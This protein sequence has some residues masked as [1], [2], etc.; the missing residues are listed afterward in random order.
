M[1]SISRKKFIFPIVVGVL[2]LLGAILLVGVPLY[3]KKLARD[4][5][6]ELEK[7]KPVLDINLEGL[8]VSFFSRGVRLTRLSAAI[9][10]GQ[11][12]RT[13]LWLDELS[14]AGANL[15]LLSNPATVKGTWAKNLTL[16]GLRL[17]SGLG[18]ATASE[19]SLDE[20]SGDLGR[21]IEALEQSQKP[22]LPRERQKT[23]LF[24]AAGGISMDGI[25]A[26]NLTAGEAGG[27]GLSLSLE[28]LDQKDF[29][30]TM[31]G[32][33]LAKNLELKARKETIWK[34]QTLSFTKL[35]AP[36][37]F[38][39][40]EGSLP[41]FLK[42]F[43]ASLN[44]KLQEQAVKAPV[45]LS[46]LTIAGARFQNGEGKFTSFDELLLDLNLDAALGFDFT[47][48]NL[49]SP[50]LPQS[51]AADP[52]KPMRFDAKG[53]GSLPMAEQPGKNTTL[54]VDASLSGL[55]ALH[56]VLNLSGAGWQSL[57]G[58]QQANVGEKLR[59]I[60]GEA[61]LD[62]E[63]RL[64]VFLADNG[65]LPSKEILKREL[66]KLRESAKKPEQE[67]LISQILDFLNNGGAFA[68]AV[69]PQK[70]ASLND[71]SVAFVLDPSLL[72]LKS[73]YTPLPAR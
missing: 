47:V 72:D 36:G 44:E 16:R 73:S 5:R 40:P 18:D 59:L 37:W 15:G 55:G 24:E 53:S 60:N 28:S 34:I 4:A 38:F 48:K 25:R 64:M 39:G 62:D 13:I 6:A 63:G 29:S 21:L 14:L 19:I 1:N 11:R 10:A 65:L 50:A 17:E 67:N 31:A 41:D 56:S 54:A 26:S 57:L 8:D 69:N 3:E 23:L 20:I 43:P 33:C 66:L 61:R 30:L 58:G 12:T 27:K 35:A 22:D 70:P 7:L 9:N 52:A 42:N 46:G 51:Y 71:I 68:L 49:I 32:P 2:L 45:A